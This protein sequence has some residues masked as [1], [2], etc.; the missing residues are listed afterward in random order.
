M[1]TKENIAETFNYSYEDKF[2]IEDDEQRKIFINTEIDEWIIDTVVYA[3][4]R[5]NQIDKGKPVGERKPIYIYINSSGGSV[6][7]GLSLVSI[8][9]NSVTPVYTINLAL[10][11]SMAF[12]IFIAGHKRFALPYSVFLCHETS[13][14]IANST[15]KVK[16]Q[17]DFELNEIGKTIKDYVISQTKIDE[18]LYNEKYK[19]EWYFMPQTAKELGVVDYIIGTDCVMDDI[20]PNSSKANG[21]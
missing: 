21:D 17:I 13:S 19:T 3:I 2:E 4:L 15:S 20:L 8:I 9:K 5:Y 6:I 1:N 7:D 16:E 14:I 11:A 10:A 12:H 18:K